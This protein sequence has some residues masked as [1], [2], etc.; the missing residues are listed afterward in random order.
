MDTVSEGLVIKG[1]KAETFSNLPK[2]TLRQAGTWGLGFF[3][4]VPVPEQAFRP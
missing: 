3:T 1:K 4:T 2:I